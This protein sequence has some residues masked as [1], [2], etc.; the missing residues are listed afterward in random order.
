MRFMIMQEAQIFNVI[1][2][3]F[4]PHNSTNKMARR[5]SRINAVAIIFSCT[6]ALGVACP[7]PV[8]YCRMGPTPA[9]ADLEV[10]PSGQTG[11]LPY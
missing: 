1:I 11:V 5:R 2:N 9:A 7:G 10:D 4:F 6:A 8:I 3:F